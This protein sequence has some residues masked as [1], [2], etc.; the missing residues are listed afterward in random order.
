MRTKKT[1]KPAPIFASSSGENGDSEK[2]TKDEPPTTNG[3]AAEEE[4]PSDSVI[5][6]DNDS[7]AE[8]VAENGIANDKENDDAGNTSPKEDASE[9]PAIKSEKPPIKVIRLVSIEKLMRPSLLPTAGEDASKKKANSIEKPLSKRS[10]NTSVIEISD[11]DEDDDVPLSKKAK[12]EEDVVQNLSSDDEIAPVKKK[13]SQKVKKVTLK[14]LIDD[15]EEDEP[16]AKRK[17]EAAKSD[18]SK[19]KKRS[20][21][22][23]G[24]KNL[25][26]KVQK[27][28][29]DL[30]SFMEEHSL[31][32][33]LD[34]RN[35]E[36]TA[37]KSN[38]NYYGELGR[39]RKTGGAESSKSK[40]K[41]GGKKGGKAQVIQSSDSEQNDS[42][43]PIASIITKSDNIPKNVNFCLDHVCIMM[44]RPSEVI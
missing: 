17:P 10:K 21:V 13:V 9:E 29:S 42:D 5:L 2:V 35:R 23:D 36:I 32:S 7:M 38:T 8:P 44:C 15:D 41:E 31:S 14:K 18:K 28:P 34:R 16:V 19:Q 37:F 25:T 11:S 40:A 39:R 22:P 26:V 24:C 1:T 12:A 20:S 33:I 6:I 30:K 3:S 43:E 4:D 27:L